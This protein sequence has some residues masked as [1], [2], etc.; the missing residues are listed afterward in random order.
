MPRYSTYCC[1]ANLVVTLNDATSVFYPRVIELWGQWADERAT[2]IAPRLL[3]YEVANAVHRMVRAGAVTSDWAI[4][5]VQSLGALPIRF[6]DYPGIHLDAL[7]I[8]QEFRLPAAY[9]SHY[10]A[11]ARTEGVDFFTLDQKLV[12]AVAHQ[13]P[14]VKLAL[15]T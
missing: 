10:L 12:N 4:E 1:D 15:E 3:R 6:V 13:L 11:L 2:L 5:T 8:A 14:F 7:A 9:D